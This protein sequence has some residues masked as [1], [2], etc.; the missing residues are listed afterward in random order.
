M[1]LIVLIL[2]STSMSTFAGTKKKCKE[3]VQEDRYHC[4]RI[5]DED[6]R[7]SCTGIV[8]SNLQYCD[9]VLSEDIRHLCTAVVVK[10][11]YYCDRILDEEIQYDCKTIINEDCVSKI[12]KTE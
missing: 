11:D 8:E 6:L 9:R 1:K 5:L 12:V 10:N 7:N 3:L 4:D 2:L